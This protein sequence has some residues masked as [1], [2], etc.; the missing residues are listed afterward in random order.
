[1]SSV[2]PTESA[3]FAD[4]PQPYLLFLGDVTESGFAKTAFG[5]RDWASERCVGQWSC[6]ATIDTGLPTVTPG[7]ARAMGARGLV[8]GVASPGGAIPGHW[9]DA[10]VEA[11]GAGLD[12]V[13]GMHTR[14]SSI[15]PLA[16]A[17]R[18]LGRRLI[19]VR[20]PPDGLPVGTGRPRT[21]RRLLTVGTD[22]AVGK[23]YT[24][25]ALAKALAAQGDAVDFRASGQTGILIAGRGVPMD[26]VVADFAAGAAERLSPD[27]PAAHWDIV[28][29]QGSLFH[30]AYAGVSLALLHGTQPD[31]FVVCHQPDRPH[32]LGYPDFALPDVADVIE[33]TTRLG[34]RI[35][36]RIRC[37]GVAFDTSRLDADEALA[38]MTAERARLGLP[39]ADPLRGGDAFAALVDA[40]R[41][42]SP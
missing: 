41:A 32:M 29:G 21:G 7:E 37:V 25:L 39:V 6:G 42:V 5:L 24:A 31:A 17:A 4:L 11:L 28:E 2:L 19:D 26:A 13:S 35:N 18:R 14:L 38:R 33:L 1:M 22:C 36:P 3:E 16:D 40:V 12:L 9:I 10:L 20:V 15:A 30:P 34:Q 23:K 8:I 27:A